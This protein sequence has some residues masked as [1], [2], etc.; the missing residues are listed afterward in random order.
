MSTYTFTPRASLTQ[1]H[2][3]LTWDN[4]FS[5]EELDQIINVCDRLPIQKAVISNATEADEFSDI[6][7]SKIGW[8]PCT[9]ESEWI[10]ERLSN[11]ARN[12]NAQFYGFDLYGFVEHMQYTVYESDANGHY[13]WHTD[14]SDTSAS[15]RKFSLVLQ[16]S[17]P[18]EY[19]GGE[20]QT[21]TQPEPQAVDKKR[22]LIAAFPSWALH[23]V[24]PVTSGVRRTLVV[25]VAG[26]Q[27]K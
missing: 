24:T 21:F 22:G 17:D 3:F 4:A 2:A 19:E 6:R 8:L 23:R 26:P 1:N 12:L 5:N 15:P 7:A 14:L 27:F 13:T 25:W 10:Y 11:V 9:Q 18:S 20:L 16:L